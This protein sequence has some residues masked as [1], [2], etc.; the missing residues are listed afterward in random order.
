MKLTLLAVLAFVP[1]L[2]MAQPDSGTPPP[3]GPGQWKHHDESPD[4]QLAHLTAKLTLTTAEQD[5]IKPV[6]VSKDEQMKAIFQNTSLTPDQKHEQIK[7]LM[8]STKTKIESYL[9]PAQVT[10]FESMHEHHHDGGPGGDKEGG[11]KDGG[12]GN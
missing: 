3:G 8:D 9:T 1:C 10:L 11:D 12:S 5:E 2:A 6:L 4:Q 7:A